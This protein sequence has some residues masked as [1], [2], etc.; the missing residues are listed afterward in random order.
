MN[1]S[2]RP[3]FSPLACPE[4][5]FH[6]GCFTKKEG[7]FT[8]KYSWMGEF[9]QL[10]IHQG[11]ICVNQCWNSLDFTIF[12]S[13]WWFA[14][15][16]ILKY[17]CTLGF[18]PYSVPVWLGLPITSENYVFPFPEMIGCW[19]ISHGFVDLQEYSLLRV[20]PALT[21]ICHS[22]WHIIWKNII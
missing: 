18:Q 16:G 20:I 19:W 7:D 15:I 12:R 17:S 14:A 8:S 6:Q 1:H 9:H 10:I 13:F 3:A 2:P 11:K 5:R 4:W 21:L 22:F